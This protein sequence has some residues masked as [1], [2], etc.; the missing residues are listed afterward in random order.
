MKQ[1]LPIVLRLV[2]GDTGFACLYA[3]ALLLCLLPSSAAALPFKG[4]AG[5]SAG[6]DNNP[7]SAR[8]GKSSAFLYYRAE[9]GRRFALPDAL[10]LDMLVEASRRDYEHNK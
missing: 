4:S 9:L 1:Q 2:A 10:L 8:H 5:I 7:A 3:A 6:Y